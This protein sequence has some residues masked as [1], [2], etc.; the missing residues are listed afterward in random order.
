MDF[1]AILYNT[2]VVTIYIKLRHKQSQNDPDYKGWPKKRR[3]KEK[4]KMKI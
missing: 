3:Q 1:S 2:K 4:V